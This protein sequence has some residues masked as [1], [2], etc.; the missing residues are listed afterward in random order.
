LQV[1]AGFNDLATLFPELAAE[2]AK[3]DP[4]T[5]TPK[6]SKKLLWRCK[7]G[8]VWS[9]VV[10]SRTP[11]ASTGCPEC[12]DHGFKTSLPAWFYLLE[13]PGEQQLGITNRLKGR[14]YEHSR[15]GWSEVEV[16]GP[17]PGNQVLA[18]EKKLKRWLPKEVGLVPG[19]HEN[20]FTSQLEVQSLAE[21]KARS[22][23]ETDLF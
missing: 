13:R 4:K 3:G 5:V 17:F 10:A 20:W 21:L 19:T 2:V 9:A 14:Y 23:V 1:L 7:E 16:V 15:Y 6:S 18:L 11:P 8:H 22:G 12:S